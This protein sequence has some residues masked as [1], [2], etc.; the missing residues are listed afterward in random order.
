MDE[1]QKQIYDAFM[2][3]AK[4]RG[5]PY[6]RITVEFGPQ[7]KEICDY[8]KKLQKFENDSRNAHIRVGA[9]ETSAA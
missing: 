1:T 8:L 5:I 6:K 9:L 7:H 2:K 4:E 3:I